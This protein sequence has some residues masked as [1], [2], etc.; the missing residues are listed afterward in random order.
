MQVSETIKMRLVVS[1]HGNTE[2]FSTACHS[3]LCRSSS[4][5]VLTIELSLQN[6]HEISKTIVD[7]KL[8]SIVS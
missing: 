2:K 8:V 6:F 1:C 5:N 3:P 4:Y 7:F